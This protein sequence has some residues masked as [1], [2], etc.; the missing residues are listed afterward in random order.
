MVFDNQ[1]CSL[2]YMQ[3]LTQF[4]QENKKAET[5]TLLTL[6]N[7]CTTEELKAQQSAILSLTELLLDSCQD[8][9]LETI[10]AI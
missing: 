2:V 9:Q 7:A 6:A 8:G 4:D 5:N 10:R 1:V 3:D